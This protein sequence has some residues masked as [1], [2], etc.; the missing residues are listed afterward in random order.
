[1]W[2]FLLA[3]FPKALTMLCCPQYH[4]HPSFLQMFLWSVKNQ[5]RKC[6]QNKTVLMLVMLRDPK[7]TRDS[8]WKQTASFWSTKY[9]Y[10]IILWSLPSLLW[11]LSRTMM[12]IPFFLFFF[13]LSKL[14]IN[15]CRENPCQFLP[16]YQ[17]F[18]RRGE[19]IPWKEELWVPDDGIYWRNKKPPE[20][21]QLASIYLFFIQSYNFLAITFLA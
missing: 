16:N 8:Q 7:E 20:T 4:A 15:L 3:T 17:H 12:P 2:V 21:G 6:W 14:L 19:W 11:H 5:K 18:L 1:M 13:F 9:W 10:I